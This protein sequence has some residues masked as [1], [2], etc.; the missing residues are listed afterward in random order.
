M[1]INIVQNHKYDS[2]VLNS[3]LETSTVLEDID[4]T[5][6]DADAKRIKT[7]KRT[8]VTIKGSKELRNQLA[9]LMNIRKQLTK[10]K[11]RLLIKVFEKD[12]KFTFKGVRMS[13]G[14]DCEFNC[15]RTRVNNFV[16]DTAISEYFV[17]K[18][19]TNYVYVSYKRLL[20]GIVIEL[21]GE[22][23]FEDIESSIEDCGIVGASDSDILLDLDWISDDLDDYKGTLVGNS[24]YVISNKFALDYFL[25][26]IKIDGTFDAVID[27]TRMKVLGYILTG[28][29]KI[30]DSYKIKL[31]LIDKDDTG[32]VFEIHDTEECDA[33]INEL[34]RPVKARIFGRKFC[35]RPDVSVIKRR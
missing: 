13:A 29:Y 21:L 22:D 18:T 12:S 25:D 24:E 7:A 28:L 27:S 5:L 8:E 20:A 31:C 34:R 2:V 3:K 10:S 6:I 14:E 4:R 32:F 17:T 26:T 33:F 9:A 11:E 1:E 19:C 16:Y 30:A 35:F 15:G 23:V